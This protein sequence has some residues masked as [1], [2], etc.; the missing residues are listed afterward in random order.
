[1]TMYVDEFSNVIR[2]YNEVFEVYYC[3]DL[4]ICKKFV[5]TKQMPKEYPIISIFH[6]NNNY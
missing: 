3:N 1:M 2:N 6:K 4:E 5:D